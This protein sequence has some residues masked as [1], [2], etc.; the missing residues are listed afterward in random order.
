M[1]ELR[2]PPFRWTDGNDAIRHLGIVRLQQRDAKKRKDT[3]HRAGATNK[4]APLQKDENLKKN[5]DRETSGTESVISVRRSKR[6]EGQSSKYGP[7]TAITTS[8][9]IK[10]ADVED[11]DCGGPEAR[12]SPTKQSSEETVLVSHR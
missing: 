11:Q 3:I 5:Q 6:H 4:S 10:E 2:A 9:S 12:G 7:I 1:T 8:S